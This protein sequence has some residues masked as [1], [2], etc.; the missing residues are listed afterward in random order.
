MQELVSLPEVGSAVV[1]MAQGLVLT[2]VR[3][4]KGLSQPIS[5]VKMAQ[6]KQKY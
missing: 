1:A 6:W 5:P 4:L 2:H 3:W